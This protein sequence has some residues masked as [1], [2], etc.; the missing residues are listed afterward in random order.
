[1]GILQDIRN[2]VSELAEN[3]S[4]ADDRAFGY[5]F[6][7]K[8][9]D[10]SHEAAQDAVVDGPWD[11]G[12]DA[13]Y[14][15]ED[16][17]IFSIYQLKYSDDVSYSLTG[18]SDLQ[19]GIKAE[20]DNV[21]AV[22]VVR[23]VLVTIADSEE[24]VQR[25]EET[26]RIV[27]EWLEQKNIDVELRVEIVDL[28]RFREFSESIIGVTVSTEWKF[29]EVV[30]ES[31]ETAILGLLD[32]TCFKDE[33]S[34]ES[35]FSFNIR[36]FLGL[37]KGS[38]RWEIFKSIS[39]PEQRKQFW[40][41]N[42]GIVCLCTDYTPSNGGFSFE[43]F[44]I[45]NGAQT[46]NTIVKFLEKNPAFNEPIWVVAKVVKVARNEV[47]RASRL[48]QTSN[49]Q[50]PTG[51][52]DLRATDMSHRRIEEWLRGSGYTYV[53]RRGHRA[54]ATDVKMKDIAQAY[55]AFHGGEPHVSFAR[56]GTIFA[57]N[58]LYG[59]PFPSSEI[60]SLL[61]H[62]EE[63]QIKEF[64]FSRLLPWKIMLRTRDYIK[65]ITSGGG[66][67]KKWKS[68]AYHITWTYRE[69]LEDEISTKSYEEVFSNIDIIMNEIE[70]DVFNSIRRVFEFAQS[71]IPRVLKSTESKDHIQSVFLPSVDCTSIKDKI[72]QID[73]N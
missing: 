69:L 40:V 19:R 16:E 8:Y 47:E 6:L 42:N 21:R 20:E 62:G 60:E 68:L 65:T 52:K 58:D 37:H 48:T 56:P 44:T 46:V 72:S 30:E 32:A 11:G 39:D 57:R 33:I 12:R 9:E 3:L 27:R 35:L 17:Q 41:L 10:L 5:W 73:T 54:S 64:V 66:V 7:E 18:I 51:T 45:V 71:D 22:D 26:D 59:K 67:D 70:S 53:F 13:I 1:M 25:K 55:I 50:T 15:D 24:F 23:L 2:E 63:H 29:K 4:I 36:R 38:I 14:L 61:D 28:R 31:E 43:N 34:D 49:T